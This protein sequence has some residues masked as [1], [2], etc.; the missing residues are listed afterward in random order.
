MSLEMQG[1]ILRW[2]WSITCWIPF[3]TIR[4]K[5]ETSGLCLV[6]SFR[7]FDDNL[8]HRSR[9][10]EK[11]R[12]SSLSQLSNFQAP[13]GDFSVPRQNVLS[14]PHLGIK[15]ENMLVKLR[16]DTK[17]GLELYISLEPPFDVR[18]RN[19]GG[20]CG[21]RGARAVRDHT[22]VSIP[23]TSSGE[24]STTGCQEI[25]KRRKQCQ[26]IQRGNGWLL[27][28]TITN[29]GTRNLEEQSS[30]MVQWNS[31]ELLSN[32]TAAGICSLSNVSLETMRSST[33]LW[34]LAKRTRRVVSW[35]RRL[36]LLGRKV[37]ETTKVEAKFTSG[38]LVDDDDPTPATRALRFTGRTTLPHVALLRVSRH[39]E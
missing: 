8:R 16:I 10:A 27:L 30:S 12:A 28:L 37:I 1:F 14:S 38:A 19:K 29:F 21:V 17:A 6:A 31:D 15:L 20:A 35:Y 18:P 7:F 25:W 4:S 23:A 26:Y 32:M 22:Q 39:R 36:E 13:G 2:V 24:V 11:L 3:Y 9:S 34:C 5:G 33:R